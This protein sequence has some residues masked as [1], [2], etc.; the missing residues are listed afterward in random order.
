MKPRLLSWLAVAVL[1]VCAASVMWQLEPEAR[2]QVPSNAQIEA[3]LVTVHTTHDDKDRE[4]EFEFQIV[5]GNVDQPGHKILGTVKEGEG[6]IWDNRT[7][8][9]IRVPLAKPYAF[10]DRLKLSLVHKYHNKT[11]N[12]G[13]E[14]RS[15]AKAV[16]GGGRLELVLEET[17]DYKLGERG[18]P[19]IKVMPFNK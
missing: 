14:G 13:W 8:R 2:A 9:E 16:L 11:G 6:V 17:G 18:N 4:I 12:Q 15:S 7:K 10:K 5:E 1:A 3:I 19:K